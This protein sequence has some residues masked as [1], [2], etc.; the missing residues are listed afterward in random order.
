LPVSIQEIYSVLAEILESCQLQ[1]DFQANDYLMAKE[2]DQD[3]SFLKLVHVDI[4]IDLATGNEKNTTVNIVVKNEELAVNK[5]N[6]A[7]AKM[8]QIKQVISDKYEAE[9]L[10]NKN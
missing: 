3:V 5:N 4:I 1:V 7:F 8:E 2:K 6:H 9:L 10:S